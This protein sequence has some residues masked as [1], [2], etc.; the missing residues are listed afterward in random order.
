MADQKIASV[1]A[2]EQSQKKSNSPAAGFA[3]NLSGVEKAAI[4]LLS[5]SEPDAANIMKHLE[6]KQMQKVGVAMTNMDNFDHQRV[7]SVHE[8]FL[9]DIQRF[10][11]VGFN[12]E[13]FIRNTLTTA[14]GKDKAE[15]LIKQILA[16][17]GTRGMESLKW[18]DSSQ[19]AGII[20][21]EHPQIQSIVLSFL[22][23]QQAAEI[24]EALPD[25]LRLDL[26]T[27]IAKLDKVQPAA[28]QELNE[29]MEKQFEGQ[30]GSQAAQLGGIKSAADIMNLLDPAIESQI[31]DN[32]NDVDEAMAQ[33]I[34][35]LMFVF[36][37]LMDIDDR[38]IQAILRDV[39]SDV[40][41]KALKGADDALRDKLLG[42]MSKRAADM[43]RDDLDAMG[44]IRVSDVEEAQKQV[45]EITRKLADS[46]TV[47]LSLGG[48]DGFL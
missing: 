36:A 4:F 10:S 32:I 17:G 7:S 44:P 12:S 48:G 41:A 45:L 11:S 38:G 39:D 18:M 31:M 5:L 1:D 27:R 43:L 34:Q 46:G 2:I 30:G 33:K 24:L 13:Q 15:N 8:R 20:K 35:D 47:M 19:V 6:P 22:E 23:P 3:T 40:L 37:N 28:L 29:I 42:N 9:H 14:L 26:I 25:K 21:N 16:T